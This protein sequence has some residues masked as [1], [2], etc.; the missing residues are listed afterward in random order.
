MKEVFE[1]AAPKKPVG[2]VPE[3]KE[4]EAEESVVFIEFEPELE[5]KPKPELAIELNAK[6]ELEPRPKPEIDSTPEAVKHRHNIRPM[7]RIKPVPKRGVPGTRS[8]DR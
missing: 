1:T 8:F 7:A 5:L 6:P 2:F 4:K 3:K